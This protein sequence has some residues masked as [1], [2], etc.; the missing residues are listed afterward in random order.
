VSKCN[1]NCR[2]FYVKSF[3]FFCA[4]LGKNAINSLKVLWVKIINL[5]HTQFFSQKN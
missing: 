4:H 1:N 5:F 2:T 3:L